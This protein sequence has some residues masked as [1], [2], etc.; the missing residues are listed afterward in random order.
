MINVKFFMVAAVAIVSVHGVKAA[1]TVTLPSD[2]LIIARQAGMDL[3]IALM[4]SIKRAI[5]GK[6]DIKSFKDAGDGIGAWG[7][8][9]PGLFPPGT[10]TGHKTRAL[11]GIW[12]DRA[13][14]EK[15]AANLTEAAQAMAKAAA[16]D[17]QTEFA[18]AYQS[19]GQACT[20]CHRSYRAR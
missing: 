16:S 19:T 10:E 20:A 4:G 8:A 13:E 3:Q 15:A 1:G 6:A 5:E 11:P 17:N 2:N 9:I 7:R 12:S 18:S 14:F